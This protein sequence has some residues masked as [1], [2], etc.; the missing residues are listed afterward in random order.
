MRTSRFS[1]PCLFFLLLLLVAPQESLSQIWTPVLKWQH[2]GCYSS[3]C[4]TGWYSSPAVADLDNDGTMEVVAATYSIF[5]LNGVNGELIKKIDPPGGR[6]WP[7]V[8]LADLDDDGSREIITAHGSGYLHVLDQRGEGIWSRQ[9]ISSELRGLSVSDLDNDS[10]LEI[11]VTGAVSS[12]TNTWIYEH[13]GTLRTGWPQLSSDLGYAYGTFN[14]T[15]AV[16]DLNGDGDSEVIVPSDVHYICAYYDDG[17]HIQSNLIYGDKTWG[18]VGVWESLA[19]ELRGWGY[20]NG[21]RDES[22]RT[23]FA[24]GAG[25]IADMNGDGQPEIVVTGNVYDCETYSSKY[26]GLYLFNADRS[27]FQDTTFDWQT[28]PL[29]TGAPLTEDYNTI[30]NAIPNPAVA[31]L[32]GDGLQETLFPSYDGRLHAFWLDKTEH[33]N[34]PFSVYSSSEGVYRFA[35]EPIIV[36]LDNNGSAEVIFTSWVQKE[37]NL[38][39]KLHILDHLGNVLHELLLPDGFGSANWNGSLAAPTIANI[40]NDSDMELVINTAHSGVV[41]YDLPDTSLARILWGTGR[42][43]Y[44]RSGVPYSDLS[45]CPADC[46]GDGQVSSADLAIFASSFGS[47][48]CAGAECSGDADRDRDV[49]AADLAEI[50]ASLGRTNCL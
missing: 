40:D 32:D 22:Y 33:G 8:V 10:S 5:I 37:S 7:D 50:A 30:E 38:T 31:D 21:V 13:D 23:N 43:S 14:D 1:C 46:S 39:G 20:C 24:H 9:P 11:I 44:H 25:A 17:S 3:W 19:T 6:A 18:Q 36:D 48:N 49:D 27:R 34:W 45:K 42:G 12:K 47:F 4:E 41:A 28:T 15:A 2:G 26:T 16:G 35:S 29:N